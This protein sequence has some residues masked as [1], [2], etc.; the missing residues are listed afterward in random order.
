MGRMRSGWDS[1]QKEV[2]RQDAAF[3]AGGGGSFIPYM[4]L[5]DDGDMAKI[6]IVTEHE[7]ALAKEKG[8]SHWLMSGEFH[9][10]YAGV[11]KRGKGIWRTALCGLELNDEG[12]RHG[13]CE[14]CM[15]DNRS[16]TNFLL[17]V[18]VYAIYHTFQSPDPKVTWKVGTFGQQKVYGEAIEQFKV[19]Q[20]GYFMREKLDTRIKRYGT[21]TDRDYLVTR[22]GVRDQQKVTRDLEPMDPP[23]A[24]S[25]DLISRAVLLPR[26]EDIAEG[27]VEKLGN[28]S[29]EE[30]EVEERGETGAFT[31][32][33]LP[34]I[35]N[36]ALDDL[37]F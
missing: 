26:L 36:A 15:A 16:S 5:V 4:R 14:H 31:E 17:W 37:P 21:L 24:L 22:H 29:A 10:Y 23:T 28:G 11:S 13:E 20:D 32:V 27:R 3:K 25:A 35:D 18:Y 8:L 34:P 6:R 19:W 2:A 12:E 7:E 9:R 1:M 30:H 33:N